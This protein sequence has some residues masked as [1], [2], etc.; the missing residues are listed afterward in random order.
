[1]GHAAGFSTDETFRMLLDF[2][3]DNQSLTVSQ[4]DSAS[5]VVSGTGIYYSKDEGEAESYNNNKHRTIYLDY[6]YVDGTDSYAVNDSLVF[7]DTDVTFEEFT[8]SVFEP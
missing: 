7:V 2:N 3:H 5:A 4:L 1:M 8:V 6:T